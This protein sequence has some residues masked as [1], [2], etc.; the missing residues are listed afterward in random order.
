M[1]TTPV[2]LNKWIK[3]STSEWE[4]QPD[5]VIKNGKTFNEK[6][7]ITDRHIKRHDSTEKKLKTIIK[8]SQV[9]STSK[10]L[11]YQP[12]KGSSVSQI[13]ENKECL[14]VKTKKKEKLPVL[15]RQLFSDKKITRAQIRFCIDS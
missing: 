6:N 11:H 13:Y 1:T 10:K 9:T 5:A 14:V 8:Q 3:M 7:H 12:Q 4:Y 2:E 15:W